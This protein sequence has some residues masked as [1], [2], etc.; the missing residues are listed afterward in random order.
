MANGMA[1]GMGDGMVNGVMSGVGS[2]ARL[3]GEVMHHKRCRARTGSR[4]Y[5]NRFYKSQNRF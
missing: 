5:E 2:G 4:V 1:N 3:I